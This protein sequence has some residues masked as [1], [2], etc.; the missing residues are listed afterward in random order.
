MPIRPPT[1]QEH[2]PTAFVIGDGIEDF[3]ILKMRNYEILEDYDNGDIDYAREQRL[4]EEEEIAKFN[5][6]SFLQRQREELEN[7]DN[8]EYGNDDGYG[9]QSDGSNKEDT[10]AQ[11]AARGGG[12]RG[13]GKKRKKYMKECFA[14]N[15][16]YCRSELETI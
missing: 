3:E 15:T 8:S 10:D 5:F 7:M 2:S 4:R 1:P 12:S 9:S 13:V 6:E 11:R 16:H 14:L